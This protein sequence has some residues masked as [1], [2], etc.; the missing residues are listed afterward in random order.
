MDIISNAA[1]QAAK[2]VTGAG[3][4]HK[5]P[6]SGVT[7]NVSKG[8]PYDAGNM[9]LSDQRLVANEMHQT[10]QI[11]QSTPGS[12]AQDKDGKDH[13]LMAEHIVQDKEANNNVNNND[14]GNFN[15][16]NNDAHVVDSKTMYIY[17]KSAEQGRETKQELEPNDGPGVMG[18]GPR[19]LQTVAKEHGG[20]A[21]NVNVDSKATPPGT[22]ESPGK[23]GTDVN[24]ESASSK[25]TGE[26]YV[27]TTGFAAD[28]GNFD[29]TQ[30]GAGREAYRLM[31]EKGMSTSS[32]NSHQGGD[33]DKD[34]PSLGER[35]KHKL[36][37]H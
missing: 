36:H 23:Y 18:D 20:D 7:G 33:D 15:G 3:Q 10:N 25:G 19:P 1:N 28:G 32:T 37:K 21:G 26:Q 13:P 24:N 16:T 29:A 11:H 8:E 31:E 12:Q 9:A 27:K 30:P 35:I 5:E 22:N 14:N 4:E 34:K 2:I 6:I 17:S